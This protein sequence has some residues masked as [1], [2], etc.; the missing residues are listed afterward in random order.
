MKA[1]FEKL[2]RDYYRPLTVYAMQ[3]L[4]DQQAAEDVVQDTFLYLFRNA[5]KQDVNRHNLY[6][7]TRFRALNAKENQRRRSEKDPEIQQE[8]NQEPDD[9]LELIE[10][11]EL[12]Y[13]YF[14]VLERVHPKSR[15]I[16]LMSRSGGMK[17]QEIADK[18]NIS[19]RTVETHISLVLKVLRKKLN[20]YLIFILPI[21]CFWQI[22]IMCKS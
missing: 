1:D 17:N 7:L 22:F 11:V 18:L 16:F 10:R 8:L 9:P 19:K 6:R 2:F 21:C 15:Q 13:S 12:E 5:E 14:Q 4:G 3:F 20:R